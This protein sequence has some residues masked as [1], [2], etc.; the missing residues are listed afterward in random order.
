[1]KNLVFFC[2][3]LFPLL[4]NAQS[5]KDIKNNGIRK[6]S[7][8]NV[9]TVNGKEVKKLETV[10]KYDENGRETE[11]TSYDKKTGKA[12]KT[13]TYL[14]DDNGN[15]SKVIEK[16]ATGKV[17]KTSVFKYDDKEFKTEKQILDATGK[18]KSKDVYVYEKQ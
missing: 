7:V 18:Q 13:E 9:S 8:Y 3:L 2:I 10:T 1:M 14:Y 15:K 5:K 11:E 16:D 17:V 4:L 6:C 12:D